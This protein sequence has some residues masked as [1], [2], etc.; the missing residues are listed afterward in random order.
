MPKPQPGDDLKRLWRRVGRGTEARTWAARA[1]A[2]HAPRRRMESRRS[3]PGRSSSARERRRACHTHHTRQDSTPR[4]GEDLW[5][6]IPNGGWLRLIS[7]D[8]GARTRQHDSGWLS[9]S[10]PQALPAGSS[11]AH[12]PGILGRG[13]RRRGDELH[14]CR[15]TTGG[16][17]AS[18]IGGVEEQV[19]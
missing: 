6:P 10:S 18:G 12:A 2:R 19:G 16:D 4:G 3:R 13:D 15:H 7:G 8:D 1:A 17:L 9:R 11:G 14:L 5:E